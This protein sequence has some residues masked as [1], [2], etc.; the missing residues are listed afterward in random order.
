[1][2]TIFELTQ[3]EQFFLDHLA[4]GTL[5]HRQC[6]AYGWCRKYDYEPYELAPLGHL[7]GYDYT[8][9]PPKGSWS[10]PWHSVSQFRERATAA[11]FLRTTGQQTIASSPIST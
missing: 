9:E 3:S 10:D 4:Y 7:R 8:L 2:D 1:M 11:D 5:Q 6:F